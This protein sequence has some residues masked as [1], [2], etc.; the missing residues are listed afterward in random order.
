VR[1]AEIDASLQLTD[2]TR[3]RFV[4]PPVPGSGSL[5]SL[6]SNPIRER[7]IEPK[8]LPTSWFAARTSPTDLPHPHQ[9]V[10]VSRNANRMYLYK[11]GIPVVSNL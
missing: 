11:A 8:E 10:S 3:K 5:R 4:V 7:L 9:A 1:P 6:R 2:N